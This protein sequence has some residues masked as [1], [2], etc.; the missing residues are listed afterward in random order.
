MS[1]KRSRNKGANGEVELVN[2]L[3]AKGI[4]AQRTAPLQAGRESTDADVLAFD[5]IYLEVKR[6]E[7]LE[8]ESWCKEAESQAGERIPVIAWRRNN[9]PW[10]V[11]LLLTDFLE[12]KLPANPSD[13]IPSIARQDAA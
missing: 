12:L 10:R 7:R 5:G 8:M 2:L 6:R 13:P 3:K 9:Q 4:Q 1:G 11:S